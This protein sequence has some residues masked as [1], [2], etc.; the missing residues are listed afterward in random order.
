MKLTALITGAT[1]GIGKETARALLT[2]G[3]R[4]AIVGRNEGKLQGVRSELL[5][6]TPAGEV[7]CFQADFASL[8]SIYAFTQ[9]VRAKL[10]TL[11]VLVNNAGAI[12]D[13]RQESADGFEQTFAV[14]HLGYFATTLFL[15][16]LL[17][18]APSARIVNVA[19]GA[20]F[21]GKWR[22]DD[23]QWHTRRYRNFGAYADSKLM[24]ILFTYELARQL[25][26]TP[27]TA[28]CLHPGVVR[29]GFGQ[30]NESWLSKWLFRA[31]GWMSISPQTGAK[32]S[33]YLASSAE[34]AGVSGKYFDKC[35]P[36]KSAPLS[37]DPN[38]QAELWQASLAI[39]QEKFGDWGSKL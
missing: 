27:V 2:Q 5:A 7:L 23:L 10:S 16:K 21:L 29:T 33:V 22:P 20:H 38:I 39:L 32:T 35:K 36:V 26:G 15:L 4:V 24:N 17:Q 12:Y 31:F 11:D 9:A 6:Q 25:A 30:N 8:D 28:N 34:V 14:N 1:N 18:A 13:E 3:Y 37:Y 19:S